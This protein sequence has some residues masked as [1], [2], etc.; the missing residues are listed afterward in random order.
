MMNKNEKTRPP[1][2]ADEDAGEKSGEDEGGVATEGH[3]DHLKED[4][5]PTS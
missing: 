1:V 3:D 2:E 4:Q 5:K